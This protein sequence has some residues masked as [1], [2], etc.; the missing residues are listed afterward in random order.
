MK[1]FI[2]LF[3]VAIA[4]FTTVQ[5][6]EIT[7]IYGRN[8]MDFPEWVNL[9]TDTLR[10]RNTSKYNANVFFEIV[11]KN[12][13][14][15]LEAGDVIVLG[16]SISSTS[17][18]RDDDQDSLHYPLT[19]ALGAGDTLRIRVNSHSYPAEPMSGHSN[20]FTGTDNDNLGYISLTARIHR[21]SKFAVSNSKQ[22]TA[23][24]LQTTPGSSNLATEKAIE[25]IQ[26]FP[27]PVNSN[28][29][30]INLSNTKVEVFNVVG[31]RTMIYENATGNLNIDMTTYPNGIYFVKMQNGKSVRTE[32]IKLV[33]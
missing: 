25:K 15:E 30:I 2:L 13:S 19:E 31:Q 18:Y 10:Y 21:T 24:F 3:A 17:I 27:N 11:Y 28:L 9:E 12:G 32:K 23:Y 1:K 26:L 16:F 5:A 14:T 22:I 7:K 6:Q 29:N 33:K 4:S 8:M 20:S